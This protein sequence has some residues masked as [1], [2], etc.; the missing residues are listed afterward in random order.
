MVIRCLNEQQHIGCLLDALQHQSIASEVIVVDSGSTD[1]TLEIV[2]DYDATLLTIAPKDFSF[3]R[4]LNLGCLHASG[5]LVVIASAHV[6]PTHDKWLEKL[7][8]PFSSDKNLAIVY[9]AQRGNEIT[10]YS[11]H[12][13]FAH[14]FPDSSNFNQLHPFCNNANAVVRKDIWLHLKYNEELTGLEDI[15][16]ANRALALGYRVAYVADATVIH[17]HDE[18]SPKVYRRYYREA[19]A[20][21]R[22]FPDQKMTVFKFTRL[23]VDNILSDY[24]H[25]L[26]DGVLSTNFLDIFRFRWNQFFGTYRGLKDGEF[27]VSEDLLYRLYYPRRGF[28]S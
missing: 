11:E 15:D 1:G 17:V 7:I 14:W 27:Q 9:G 12:Q 22:I 19:L 25:A 13:I 5:S 18:P 20:L 3:G 6:Y 23:L 2:R 21:K 28:F 26:H 24:R 8:A 4:A 10:K 16:F